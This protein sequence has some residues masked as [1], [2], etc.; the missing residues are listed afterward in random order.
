M[1]ETIPAYRIDDKQRT[2]RPVEVDE[3]GNWQSVD[4]GVITTHIE[5]DFGDEGDEASIYF[6]VEYDLRDPYPCPVPRDDYIWGKPPLGARSEL[7]I[8]KFG[9]VYD[10]RWRYYT[11]PVDEKGNSLGIFLN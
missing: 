9:F 3:S 1:K 7:L 10:A 8:V 2:I 11:D 6:C 4:H 5:G